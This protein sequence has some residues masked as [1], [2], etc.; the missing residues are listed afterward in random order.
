ML[1]VACLRGS[2]VDQIG[3]QDVVH[4]DQGGIVCKFLEILGAAIPIVLGLV[5]RPGERRYLSG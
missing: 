2:R 1:E 4:L 3:L 5:Q